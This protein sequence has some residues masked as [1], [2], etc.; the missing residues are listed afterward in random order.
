MLVVSAPLVVRA[1]PNNLTLERPTLSYSRAK[2]SSTW[3]RF[4]NRRTG[5]VPCV[6]PFCPD[7]LLAYSP[8]SGNG[9]GTDPAAAGNGSGESQPPA[10]HIETWVNC[11]NQNG[12]LNVPG[13]TIQEFTSV[14]HVQ[15]PTPG[16]TN[17][18]YYYC[19]PGMPCTTSQYIKP[20]NITDGPDCDETTTSIPDTN[21]IDFETSASDWVYASTGPYT[22]G[23]RVDRFNTIGTCLGNPPPKY[24][25][26]SFLSNVGTSSVQQF[27]T[28]GVPCTWPCTLSGGWLQ[29]G[30]SN[31][32]GADEDL[33]TY[34][35]TDITYGTVNCESGTS[36]KTQTNV[37]SGDVD[38]INDQNK[39]ENAMEHNNSS[40]WSI[41]INAGQCQQETY[42]LAPNISNSVNSANVVGYQCENCLQDGANN[43]IASADRQVPFT[44]NTATDV[45]YEYGRSYKV[46]QVESLC[47]NFSSTT[48]VIGGSLYST[49]ITLNTTPLTTLVTGD[50]VTIGTDANDSTPET[51]T[52]TVTAN[53]ITPLVPSTWQYSHGTGSATYDV[54]PSSGA[55]AT[56]GCRPHNIIGQTVL[57]EINY[58]AIM[59]LYYAPGQTYSDLVLGGSVGT[60]AAPLMGAYVLNVWPIQGLRVYQPLNTPSYYTGGSTNSPTGYGGGCSGAGGPSES[61]A[62]GITDELADNMT[63]GPSSH[64]YASCLETDNSTARKSSFGSIP[65]GEYVRKF[66]AC[67]AWG[68][69]FGPC[70]VWVNPSAAG[71]DRNI[72]T[73]Y[74]GNSADFA[75]D[76]SVFHHF[77]AVNNVGPV[78]D[79]TTG[80]FTLGGTVGSPSDLVLYSGN[81]GGANPTWSCSSPQFLADTNYILT[82]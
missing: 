79:G 38:M 31:F 80:A 61:Q 5:P 27:W 37:W 19:G 72:C 53:Q 71:E 60:I 69:Y 12:C 81:S 30:Q 10:F 22:V 66:G 82:P 11:D 40:P 26:A 1:Q 49:P 7:D 16:A 75:I 4:T 41:W 74:V 55:S 23:N 52:V 17:P 43:T 58:E 14:A 25:T 65:I 3:N 35:Y 9:P 18:G 78:A 70:A 13:S 44:V 15:V 33:A 8:A 57:D 50:E 64:H 77:V 21:V 51:L 76:L 67:S 29:G 63:G 47:A 73:V 34:L 20:Y 46:R 62:G 39:F 36:A 54:V 28:A 68:T 56:L 6:R 2:S 59:F 45:I 48:S 32:S 24:K 42:S